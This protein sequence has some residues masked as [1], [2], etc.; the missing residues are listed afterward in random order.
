[1]QPKEVKR[2]QPWIYICELSHHCAPVLPDKAQLYA[3]LKALNAFL[4]PSRLKV[5]SLCHYK[6]TRFYF[7][8]IALP[9]TIGDIAPAPNMNSL[10]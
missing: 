3:F 10:K 6:F 5:K 8:A 2:I 4:C 7:A 1:M 9:N